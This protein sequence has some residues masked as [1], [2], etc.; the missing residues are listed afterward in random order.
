MKL[1][2][3]NLQTANNSWRFPADNPQGDLGIDKA[4]EMQTAIAKMAERPEFLDIAC[5]AADW[6]DECR[7][8]AL[9]G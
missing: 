4:V 6:E 8:A 5:Y 7:G 1:T 2:S 3:T 9:G